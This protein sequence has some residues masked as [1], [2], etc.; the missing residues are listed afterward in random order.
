M[1]ALWALGSTAQPDAGGRS[2]SSGWLSYS[3]RVCLPGGKSTTQRHLAASES[4]HH[5]LLCLATQALHLLFQPVPGRTPRSPLDY[6]GS[7]RK[8]HSGA[9]W[10][11]LSKVKA[12]PRGWGGG[13]VVGEGGEVGGLGGGAVHPGLCT[14]PH[15]VSWATQEVGQVGFIT[16]RVGWR[17]REAFA[18]LAGLAPPSQTSELTGG[19]GSS[20]RLCP[21]TVR[22]LISLVTSSPRKNRGRRF[23]S[24]KVNPNSPGHVSVPASQIG[25]QRQCPGPQSQALCG[26]L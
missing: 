5:A 10:V 2:R 19:V 3:R 24:R 23:S 20:W 22:D 18:L 16:E 9:A 21:G 11:A 26:V 13:V 7:C 15:C 6:G 17:W 8:T 12:E 1:R 14:S 25:I 4:P